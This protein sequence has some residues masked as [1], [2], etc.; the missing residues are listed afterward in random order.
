[1]GILRWE[2][3]CVLIG[4]GGKGEEGDGGGE[5]KEGW[6]GGGGAG[7]G[8]RGDEAAFPGA[9]Y[10]VIA[11]GGED[12]EADTRGGAGHA[13]WMCASSFRLF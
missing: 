9:V 13:D 6:G 1:M 4:D 10:G 12:E 11:T 2:G 3:V 5:G 7:G 8:V